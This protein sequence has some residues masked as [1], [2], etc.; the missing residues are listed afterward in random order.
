MGLPPTV[1]AQH[2]ERWR[3][4]ALRLEVQVRA[5]R[6][7]LLQGDSTVGEVAR[8]DD[9]VIGAS[10]QLRGI[11]AA[12]FEEFL[13]VRARWFGGAS[14]SPAGFRIVLRSDVSIQN[15]EWWLPRELATV[16]LA[17]L[18][19]SGGATRAQRA[20]VPRRIAENLIDAYGEMMYASA[21]SVLFKWLE[22]FPPL[23]IPDQERRHI[24]M[25]ALVTGTGRAQRD[26][27]AGDLAACASALRLRAQG[28]Q[29]SGS[30]YAPIVRADL[31]L[32]ALELGG[33]AAWTRFRDAESEPIET[34]L[35]EAAGMPAD[36]VL[37]RWRS[38]LL[39]L[40]PNEAP[41]S[42]SGVLLAVGWT[43]GLLLGALGVARWT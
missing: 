33:P 25:Y 10:E 36:S 32:T 7:S 35:A 22:S 34:A 40:R 15:D 14:P 5:L 3:D 11:A 2:A 29:K 20:V 17:G 16:V 39:T 23:S 13:L 9:L 24:A 26:C 27:I 31:L 28:Q 37:A 8:R 38:G 19:D 30:D 42:L 4:S 6:D 41:V 21:G 1:R 12:A 43:A 18:P